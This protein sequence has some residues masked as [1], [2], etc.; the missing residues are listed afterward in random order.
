[1]K[2][3]KKVL[4][5]EAKNLI[6]KFND[7][8]AV[9]NINFN[10]EEGEIFAFLGPN[11]A[12]KSTT[13]KMMTTV[14]SPTQ[15]KIKIGG[16]DVGLEKDKIRKLIGVIFQDTTLDD[17]LT[18]FENLYYH[19][20]LYGVPKK[21]IKGKIETLLKEVGLLDR[22]D[23]LIKRFSGGMKRRVEIARGLI[24]SPKI[25]FLDEPTI[26]LDVQTRA[27]LWDNIKKINKESGIT[28]FFTTH[29][30][31]EAEKIATKIV[32]IDHGKI[33]INGTSKEIKE[34]TNTNS[35]E[36]AFLKLTGSNIR[37]QAADGFDMMRRMKRR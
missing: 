37:E 6:K 11:G 31:D 1:M 4:A 2:E 14:L 9:D 18:A 22:K 5:I 23:D 3:D 28:I 27:F 25:L 16:F 29:N 8:T 30:L 17:D 24:H 13:I 33:L 10:V 35:L 21:E 20:L 34:K 36:E 26:G 15:G 12:G 32:I 19:S 7:F